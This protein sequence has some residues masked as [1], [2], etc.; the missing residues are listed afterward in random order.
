[1]E[2]PVFLDRR[3]GRRPTGDHQLEPWRRCHH[4]KLE[5]HCTITIWPL[6][7]SDIAPHHLPPV[8]ISFLSEAVCM[9]LASVQQCWKAFAGVPIDTDDT[10][11]V[12]ERPSA[13]AQSLSQRGCRLTLTEDWQAGG[14][15]PRPG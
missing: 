7:T 11:R 9:F 4:V 13:Q 14:S 10:E 8:I 5:L 12:R 3:L 6:C 2:H 15:C 1:M